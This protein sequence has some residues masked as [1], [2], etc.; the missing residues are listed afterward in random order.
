VRKPLF[1]WRWTVPFILALFLLM[2]NFTRVEDG[3]FH[4]VGLAIGIGLLFIATLILAWD[5]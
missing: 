2:T 1:D 3:W 5:L 4:V